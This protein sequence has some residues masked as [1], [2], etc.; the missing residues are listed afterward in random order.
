[1]LK[2]MK[3]MVVVALMISSFGS[4]VA[5]AENS[6]PIWAQTTMVEHKC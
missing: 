3:I 5:F 6:E 2:K 4:V 1:M